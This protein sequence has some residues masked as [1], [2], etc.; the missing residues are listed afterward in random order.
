[1]A[2]GQVAMTTSDASIQKTIGDATVPNRADELTTLSLDGAAIDNVM[3][4]KNQLEKLLHLL[5]K[6]VTHRS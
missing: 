4:P 5:I 6:M 2:G 3:F 1:M